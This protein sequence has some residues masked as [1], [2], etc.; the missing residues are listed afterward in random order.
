MRKITYESKLKAVGEVLT[1]R[2]RLAVIAEKYGMS[3]GYLSTLTNRVKRLLQPQGYAI[4]HMKSDGDEEEYARKDDVK[5]SIREVEEKLNAIMQRVG[6][7][8]QV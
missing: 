6:L 5:A 4:D 8:P 7:R 2:D 3:S 1:E